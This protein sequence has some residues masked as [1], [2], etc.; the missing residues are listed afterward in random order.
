MTSSS[1][2]PNLL[3]GLIPIL[4]VDPKKPTHGTCP[5]PIPLLHLGGNKPP[6]LWDTPATT[7]RSE[8][9]THIS[10]SASRPY[11]SLKTRHSSLGM[12]ALSALP[13]QTPHA[14]KPPHGNLSNISPQ[15][16]ATK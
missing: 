6:C 8:K 10:T 4:P 3:C 1:T 5:S 12:P 2:L 11:R 16:K 14:T 9:S 15:Q 7:T 13:W